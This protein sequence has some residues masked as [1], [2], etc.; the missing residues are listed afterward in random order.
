MSG[1]RSA[2]RGAGAEA[3]ARLAAEVA[4]SEKAE[5][6]V[7][8]D[9]R[10]LAGFTDFFVIAT[11]GSERRRKTVTDAV[12]RR[13]LESCGRKP[14]HLEGYP[15]AEWLL[16]DYVDFVVHIFSPESR[17]LYQVER[18][19]GDASRWFPEPAEPPATA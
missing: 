14:T 11:A 19:W 10:G 13:L 1:T 5:D 18:L 12:E 2:G 6:V 4:L 15:K 9:L 7:V 8:L 17:R 16:A 3:Q